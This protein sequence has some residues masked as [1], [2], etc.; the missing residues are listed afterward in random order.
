[1]KWCEHVF[2]GKSIDGSNEG[3]S[4]CGDIQF[5]KELNWKFCPICGTPR[6]V[7]KSLAEKFYESPFMCS[8]LGDCRELEKI[9]EQHFKDKN[10]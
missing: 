4:L 5:S 3:W 6:P 9:A 2:W 7:E 8:R 1:M 10:A